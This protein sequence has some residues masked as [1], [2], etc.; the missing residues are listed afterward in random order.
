MFQS[1]SPPW[2]EIQNWIRIY[3]SINQNYKAV[4]QLYRR[5]QSYVLL[6]M[7][8]KM[9]SST[10]KKICTCNE[11]QMDRKKVQRQNIKCLHSNK[12]DNFSNYKKL[13][14]LAVRTKPVLTPIYVLFCNKQ[15]LE[16]LSTTLRRREPNRSSFTSRMFWWGNWRRSRAS[17]RWNPPSLWCGKLLGRPPSLGSP[18]PRGG[19]PEEPSSA[20]PPLRTGL[21]G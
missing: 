19:S 15:Q 6:Y 16:S 3:F 8:E 9:D 17:F 18:L 11:N 13:L 7:R 21:E 14:K 1:F 5:Q 10:D 2:S 4:F 20:A 12:V